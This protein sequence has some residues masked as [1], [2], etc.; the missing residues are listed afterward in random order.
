[1]PPVADIAVPAKVLRALAKA[2]LVK[3]YGTSTRG[4]VSLDIV[5]RMTLGS[6]DERDA[7]RAAVDAALAAGEAVPAD[8]LAEHEPVTPA[9]ANPTAHEPAP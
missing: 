6:V 4:S 7:H 1:M 9:A 2:E 8:V 3:L 5:G